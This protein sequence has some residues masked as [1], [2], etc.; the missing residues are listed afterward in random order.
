VDISP[1]YIKGLNKRIKIKK[2]GLMESLKKLLKDI[3]LLIQLWW[4]PHYK[5][6]TEQDGTAPRL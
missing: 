5:M 1:Y 4:K 6:L 3:A 2:G